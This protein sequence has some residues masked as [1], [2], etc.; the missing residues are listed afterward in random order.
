ML[1]GHWEGFSSRHPSIIQVLL[2][3][4]SVRQ[5]K[6]DLDIVTLASLIQ[7]NDGKIIENVY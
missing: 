1:N 5:I 3:D 2:C 6:E 4:G 7:I